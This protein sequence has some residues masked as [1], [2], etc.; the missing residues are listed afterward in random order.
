MILLGAVIAYSI[1]KYVTTDHFSMPGSTMLIIGVSV[2]AVLAL[3]LYFG[4][5]RRE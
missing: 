1:Y 3:A 4:V 5:F 2:F